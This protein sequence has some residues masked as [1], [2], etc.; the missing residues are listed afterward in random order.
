MNKL[1]L[2]TPSAGSADA[3]PEFRPATSADLDALFAMDPEQYTDEHIATIVAATR[4]EYAAWVAETEAAANERR[5]P[6][7]PA[8]RSKAKPKSAKAVEREA[9][10][11]AVLAQLGLDLTAL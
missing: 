6:K 9:A 4:Q 5:A 7:S 8:T 10:A 11:N 2:P 1:T 3:E